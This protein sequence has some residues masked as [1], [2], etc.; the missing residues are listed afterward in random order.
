MMK[1]KVLIKAIF[2]AMD[3]EYDVKIPVN[4]QVWKVNKLLVKAVFDMN[5]FAYD[6]KNDNYVILNKKNGTIYDNNQIIID[7]DIRNGTELIF[8]KEKDVN[9]QLQSVK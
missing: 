4:E 1:T 7:T 2:P 3:M 9:Q 5:N 8:I 6:I